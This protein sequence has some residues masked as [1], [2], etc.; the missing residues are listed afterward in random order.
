M[1]EASYKTRRK[2]MEITKEKMNVP[3][4]PLFAMSFLSC[5]WIDQ[6]KDIPGCHVRVQHMSTLFSIIIERIFKRQWLGKAAMSGKKRWQALRRRSNRPLPGI[7]AG[8][9]AM[10]SKDGLVGGNDSAFSL[11][12]LVMNSLTRSLLRALISA[13]SSGRFHLRRARRGYWRRSSRR[14]SRPFR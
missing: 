6:R 14:W 9:A 4:D 5:L 1:P 3:I 11:Y 13:L 2:A 10:G 7:P 12:F 8:H